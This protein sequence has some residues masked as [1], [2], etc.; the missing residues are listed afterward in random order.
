MSRKKTP[1][2]PGGR[3]RS[4]EQP[5]A[6]TLSLRRLEKLVQEEGIV[7][8]EDLDALRPKTRGDCIDG[9]RPCPWVGCKY[10]LYL[11]VNEEKGS[12]KINFPNIE[13]WEMEHSCVLDLADRGP[14]TLDDVGRLM[15]LTRERI[16][17]L[18]SSAHEKIKRR[19]LAIE[20][21]KYVIEGRSTGDE[22]SYEPTYDE[23][24]EEDY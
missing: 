18:E 16:R 4:P 22:T 15:N 12:I 3:K 23:G 20:Y 9:P 10:H 1:K 8:D 14:V 11:D 21:K 13:P 7:I 17:Q 2:K 19:K 24:D 5:R 6:R